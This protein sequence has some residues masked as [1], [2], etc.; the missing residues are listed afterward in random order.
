MARESVLVRCM[1]YACST[2]VVSIALERIP[3]CD[4]DDACMR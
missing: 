3:G 4:S 2:E 1:K